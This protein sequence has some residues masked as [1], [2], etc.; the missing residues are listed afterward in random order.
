M[1]EF[2]N[3]NSFTLLGLIV[4]G[5]TAYFLFRNGQSNRSYLILAGVTLLLI[6]LF[7]VFRPDQAASKESNIFQAQIGQGKPVLLEFQSP[8]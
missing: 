1:S 6:L 7:F 3:H 2:I 8:Y 5:T 4:W